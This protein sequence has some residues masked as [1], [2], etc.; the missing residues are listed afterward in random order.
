MYGRISD[1]LTKYPKAKY[2]AG[3]RPWEV[4]CDIALPC[5]TQNELNEEEAKLLVANGCICVGEG[6]NMPSTPRGCNCFSKSKNFILTRKSVKC[7][8]CCYLRFRNVSK[9]IAIKLSQRRS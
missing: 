7:R 6:A 4:L 9:F 3:K 1:Y 2:V 8:R 5:A